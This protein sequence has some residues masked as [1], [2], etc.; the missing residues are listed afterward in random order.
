MA[1]RVPALKP[2]VGVVGLGIMGGAMA[3]ALL[4]A[5]YEVLGYDVLASA[6]QRLKKAGG[7]P[8]ASSAAVATRA[9]CVITSLATVA[10]LDH[11]AGKIA[12]ARQAKNRPGLVV[13]ETSTLPLADKARAMKRLQRAGI[14][15]LDC[16]I[17]GTAVRMKEGAWTI[18][19]SGS[20][21]AFKRVCPIL[22]VFT[23]NVPYVGAFGNGTKMKY[24][25]NHL[26]AIYNVA[27][28]EALTLARKM[29]L[30]PQL[31]LD[32]LG[33]SPVIGNGV[34]RLR[35]ALMVA[36]KYRPATMKVEV[37]QKDMQVIGDMA[38]AV[39]CPTPLFTACA[40]IYNAAMA[41]GLAQSDTASVCEVL[42]L[43]AG[44]GRSRATS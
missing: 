34:L 26:V 4:A 17:S 10:A 22:N 16:P 5:G 38:K 44:I 1:A 7:Q 29:G 32:L 8:R 3:E 43:M 28:A 14:T 25:A 11:V 18:F 31:V 20:Q 24:V 13:V 41:Q 33:P 9:D 36:R 15:T 27:A 21:A 19:A 30:D 39:D 23:R 37:W 42:A 2:T 6:R 35:G 12:T 40:P